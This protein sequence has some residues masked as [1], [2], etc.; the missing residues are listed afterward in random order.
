MAVRMHVDG[1]DALAF[2]DH[3]QA[4]ARCRLLLG[5]LLSV[6]GVQQGAAAEDDTGRCG[7]FQKVPSTH[8]FR[9]NYLLFLPPSDAPFALQDQRAR[10]KQQRLE[11]LEPIIVREVAQCQAKARAMAYDR[12]TDDG[13]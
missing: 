7:S 12:P 3:R 2:D 6:R 11:P 9:H 8:F 10:L 5:R 13:A 1:L 4:G